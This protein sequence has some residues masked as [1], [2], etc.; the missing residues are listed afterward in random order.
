MKEVVTLILNRNLGYVTNR[1]VEN[2]LKFNK[3][4]TDVYVIDSGI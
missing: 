1:L 3:S 4:Y 2:I